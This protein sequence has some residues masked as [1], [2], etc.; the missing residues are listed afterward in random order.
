VVVGGGE[1]ASRKV[2]GLLRAGASVTVVAPRLAPDLAARA[3]AGE[4]RHVAREHAD[5]DLEH[6]FLAVAATDSVAVQRRVAEEAGRRRVLLNVVDAPELSSFI[7]PALLERG[8]LQVAVSTAGAAPA[9][10]ARLR[11][12]IA[13]VVGPEWGE[14]VR[15]LR[16]VRERLRRERRTA[17][18]RQRIL[19]DL[20][21]DLARRLRAGDRDGVARVLSRALAGEAPGDGLERPAD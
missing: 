19:R 13:E 6:A 15:L 17:S 2:V 4:V 18:E 3:A 1:I 14:A 7:A 10:A 9:L 11:D 16:G 21:A 20:S 5:G 12:R 8:E